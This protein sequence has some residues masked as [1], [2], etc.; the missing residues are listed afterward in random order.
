MTR[1]RRVTKRSAFVPSEDSGNFVCW[2]PLDYLASQEAEKVEGDLSLLSCIDREARSLLRTY[3]V[4]DTEFKQGR[5]PVWGMEVGDDRGDVSPHPLTLARMLVLQEKVIGMVTSHED[6]FISNKYWNFCEVTS[7]IPTSKAG[8]YHFTRRGGSFKDLDYVDTPVLRIIIDCSKGDMSHSST[9]VGKANLHGKKVSTPRTEFRGAL[10]LASFYQDGCL[11]T[12]HSQDPKY[13]PSVMGGSSNRPLWDNPM[14]TYLYVKAYKYGTYDRIYGSASAELM[15]VLQVLERG[16]SKQAVLCSRLRDRQ[17]Y[18]HGTYDHAVFVPTKEMQDFSSL[19]VPLYLATE[20]TNR[21]QS[22]E[23]R[24]IRTK[25]LVTRREAELEFSKTQRVKEI[26]F[27][28]MPPEY[29]MELHLIQKRVAR[30]KFAN[31]LTANAAFANLLQRKASPEDYATLLRSNDFHKISTGK[32]TFSRESAVWICNGG[33]YMTVTID[34]VTEGQDMFVRS[35]VSTEESFKVGGITLKPIIGHKEKVQLTTTRV[36]L[37]QIN[38]EMLEWSEDLLNRL[39]DKQRPLSSDILLREFHKNPEWVNDDTGLIAQCITDAQNRAGHLTSVYLV[40]ADKRLANQMSQQANVTVILVPPHHVVESLRRATWTST[41]TLT[42]NE[43]DGIYT[44]SQRIPKPVAVYTDTGSLAAH[45]SHYVVE[46]DKEGRNKLF[47]KTLLETGLSKG[48]RFEKF[49]L[50]TFDGKRIRSL[51][52]RQI[53]YPV[54]RPKLRKSV[55]GGPSSS[56]SSRG[57]WRRSNT[58]SH[59]S[60]RCTENSDG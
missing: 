50:E 47:R 13:L 24:L 8:S 37:Y 7:Y 54:T 45:S 2:N 6:T 15:D 21:Y 3:K 25:L 48:K 56:H 9:A 30:S 38:S 32:Q 58:E 41:S 49:N 40:S 36:G 34:D 42:I 17:E 19:P 31:A 1:S 33:Q 46:R 51:D 23:N 39:K 5:T 60:I 10:M 53:F 11:R 43:V 18:L 20:G 59:S 12:S 57:S 29:I 44:P 28:S 22:Y 27:G 35:E 16:G 4:P 14:N 55:P 26:L 52:R